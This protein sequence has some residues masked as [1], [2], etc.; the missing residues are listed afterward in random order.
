[1]KPEERA[2]KI[3]IEIL[4]SGPYGGS[5]FLD[6]WKSPDDLT[7]RIFIGK[8]AESITAAVQAQKEKDAAI[9]R[10]NTGEGRGDYYYG[11]SDAA[12]AIADAIERG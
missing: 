2:R 4:E 9:A 6:K 11:M 8:I 5:P 3:I 12:R 10:E 1:M 7:G